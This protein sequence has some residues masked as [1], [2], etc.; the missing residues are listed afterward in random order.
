M[1]EQQGE[2]KRRKE[3]DTY[4]TST[5]YWLQDV[6]YHSLDTYQNWRCLMENW[7]S[8]HVWLKR[9]L[10]FPINYQ[11]LN[12]LSKIAELK[13]GL[14][15]KWTTFSVSSLFHCFLMSA[16]SGSIRQYNISSNTISRDR[17]SKHIPVVYILCAP[18]LPKT[19]TYLKS[20]TRAPKSIPYIT[21]LRKFN[22]S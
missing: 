12:S 19:Q 3:D 21:T 5:R 6:T 22:L 13:H 2:E 17:T 9:Y 4:T 20:R 18:F 16:R 8:R 14:M 10:S 1:C 11:T 15:H 7:I